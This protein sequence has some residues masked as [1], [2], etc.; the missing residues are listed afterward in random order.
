MRRL[1]VAGNWKMHGDVHMTSELLAGVASNLSAM[2]S[3]DHALSYD[4]LVC[5]PTVYLS[6]AVAVADKSKCVI[7]VGGQNVSEHEKGAYTGEVS[8]SMMSDVGCRYVL[9]GHSERRQYYGETDEL[10]A[11]KFAACAE[12]GNVVPVL[13]VGESLAEREAGQTEQV[14]A[15]QIQAVIDV[16]GIDGFARRYD[17]NSKT[18]VI[19]YEPVW[20]IGTGKTAT[21][22]QAQEV[23]AFIRQML[24]GLDESVAESTQILYG[25][26]VKPSNA[27]ELFA[28]GDIDGG[29]IGGASLDIDSF[30]SICEAAQKIAQS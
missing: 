8:L 9:L 20:A 4:V 25:G 16:V 18:A 14:V 12:F 24:A 3:K 17:Q 5:P 27:N 22:E 26:S 15:K 1:L 21:P 11:K 7:A 19:A 6:H 29:L 10:V 13:C 28:Q 30:T 23:H 2:S